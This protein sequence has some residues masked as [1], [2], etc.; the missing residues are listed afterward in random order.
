MV[1]AEQRL[2]PPGRQGLDRADEL[3]APVAWVAARVARTV[4]PAGDA[5]AAGQASAGMLAARVLPY[6]TLVV[7]ALMPLATG[8]YLLTT[9]AWSAAERAIVARRMRP[10]AREPGQPG[11]AARTLPQ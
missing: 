9:T 8:L 10:A 11:A 1:D 4:R 7:A 6:A 2:G 5:A 3:L